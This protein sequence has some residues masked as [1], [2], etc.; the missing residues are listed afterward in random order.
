MHKI[1]FLI[2]AL[3]AGIIFSCSQRQPECKLTEDDAIAIIKA[4]K[5]GEFPDDTSSVDLDTLQED[6]LKHV[7]IEQNG[8]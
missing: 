8:E 2:L 6:E 4:S 3:C 7:K 5:G 1:K